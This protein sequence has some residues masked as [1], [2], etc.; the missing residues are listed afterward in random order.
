MESLHKVCPILF[1]YTISQLT[2]VVFK[3]TYLNWAE[4]NRFQSMLPKD[5]RRRRD[6]ATAN[7]QTRLDPH[8]KELPI[9][10]HVAP[11]TDERF[12][13]AAI[14]WLVSTDQVSGLYP[15]ISVQFTHPFWIQLIVVNS[16]I[17]APTVSKDD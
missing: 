15:N 2:L 11:Y 16:D 3:G 5:A 13:N 12:L 10:E 14:E 17:P 8:L 7:Q 9:K 6:T 1:S 4:K